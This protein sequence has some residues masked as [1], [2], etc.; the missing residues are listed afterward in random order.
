MLRRGGFKAPTAAIS[1]ASPDHIG[2]V[3]TQ[4]T[5][6]KSRLPTAGERLPFHSPPRHPERS[7]TAVSV[8]R[9]SVRRHA[10][11]PHRT[12]IRIQRAES[13]GPADPI[14][15]ATV[16][17]IRGIGCGRHFPPRSS[18]I[19][20]LSVRSAEPARSRGRQPEMPP[21]GPEL[22][23]GHGEH[24]TPESPF[25][26]GR[27][28]CLQS[29]Y[30]SFREFHRTGLC[31]NRRR[32]RQRMPAAAVELTQTAQIRAGARHGP[33]ATKYRSRTNGSFG[34]SSSGAELICS[35]DQW[36]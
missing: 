13:K 36:W 28:S 10:P 33:G 26:K 32:M 3:C 6:E 9:L 23:K 16:S 7:L 35:I 12:G 2:P 21:S 5:A 15:F 22:R 31:R 27:W 29:G 14:R 17:A 24:E 19:A 11:V 1:G 4:R 34:V 8:H 18:D 25:L 30:R 20:A